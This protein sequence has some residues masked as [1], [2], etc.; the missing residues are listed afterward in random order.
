[1]TLYFSNSEIQIYR[2]RQIGSNSKWSLS[3]TFTVY[4][5]DIQPASPDR[6]E[7]SSNQ[8]GHVFTGFVDIGVD[9]KEGDE[10]RV[11]GDDKIYSVKG[12]SKWQ[13]A[14]IIDHVELT[15]IAKD[16]N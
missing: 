11:Q 5:A 15:L 13:G 6:V 3:A 16:D 9:V 2:L 14:G 4:E 1:M 7:L 8:I 10:L 12:V